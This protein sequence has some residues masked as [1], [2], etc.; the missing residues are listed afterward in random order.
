MRF[1]IKPEWR[2]P[3]IGVGAFAAGIGVGYAYAAKRLST[4]T[5][6]TEYVNFDIEETIRIEE[7]SD[8]SEDDDNRNQ[9]ALDFAQAI[10]EQGDVA[11]PEIEIIQRTGPEPVVVVEED[12][13]DNWNQEEEEADR[14]PD[15]A[16]VI[17]KEE[18]HDN[19]TD[20]RQA[21]LEYYS[22]DDVLCD[23]EKVP[24]YD[25]IGTVNRLEFG[26][27][28]GDTDIVYIRNERLKAEFEVIRVRGSYQHEILGLEAEEAAEESDLKHSSTIR[29][30]RD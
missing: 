30:L 14:G 21:T 16:Y 20:Y 9:L 22:G 1:Y 7:D 17:S 11:K 27:G 5:T 19:E 3:A 6:V 18:F 29:R 25:K 8:I 4:I 2:T 10:A 24:I 12:P 13:I 23:E 28:S 15:A 26:H